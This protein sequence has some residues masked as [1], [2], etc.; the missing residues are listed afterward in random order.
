MSQWLEFRTGDREVL[1]SNPAGATS[2]R[3]FGN[4][5]LK[6]TLPGSFGKDTKS[7]WSFLSGVYARGSKRPHTGGTMCNLS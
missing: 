6:P 7:C 3:N 4:S 2:L 1:G 5:V